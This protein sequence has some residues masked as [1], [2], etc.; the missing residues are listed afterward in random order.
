MADPLDAFY[1]TF[2]LIYQDRQKDAD[3][4][5]DGWGNERGLRRRCRR[6]RIGSV[7]QILATSS[8][9]SSIA[10]TGARRKVRCLCR[11]YHQQCDDGTEQNESRDNPEGVVPDGVDR[12]A[13]VHFGGLLIR[14]AGQNESRA[15]NRLMAPL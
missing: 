15:G 9:G 3:R 7:L 4:L 14:T 12:F 6:Y 5:I 2:G 10:G 11:D 8:G 1:Q 13:E